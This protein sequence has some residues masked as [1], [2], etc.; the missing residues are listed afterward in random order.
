VCPCAFPNPAKDDLLVGEI[1]LL[2]TQM[3]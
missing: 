2:F 1:R 3:P